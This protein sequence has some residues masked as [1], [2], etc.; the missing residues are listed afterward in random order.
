MA[1]FINVRRLSFLEYL[2]SGGELGGRMPQTA[3]RAL[4]AAWQDA[5]G[6]P[7]PKLD[8]DHGEDGDAEEAD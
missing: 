1:S 5:V 2:G 3:H 6:K 4:T 7:W 8:G